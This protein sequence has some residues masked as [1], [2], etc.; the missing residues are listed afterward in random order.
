MFFVL[1]ILPIWIDPLFIDFGSVKNKDLESKIIAMAEKT[2]IEGSRV[3]EI[4]K[5][6]DTKSTNARVTGFLGTKRIVL[7]DNLIAQLNEKEL[8]F[9]M[10]H[11]MGH[12]LLSHDVKFISFCAVLA[13]IIFY[14]VYRTAGGLL[15]KFKVR[16]GF[17]QLSDIASL[18]LILLLVNIFLILITPIAYS[19]S[20]YQEHEADRF[21]LEIT[22][23]NNAAATAFVKFQEDDLVNPRPGVLYILWRCT[24]PTIGDRIEFCNSYH[25]W[26]EGQPLKYESYFEK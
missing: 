13:M 15:N 14:A 6:Y 26:Q 10:G 22:Q 11:E 5:S 23:T 12:Y 7:S 4:S 21:G 8:L 19:Y 24:H 25:P 1:L 18:P 2:G 9:I 3:F 17:D 16:F 20:R